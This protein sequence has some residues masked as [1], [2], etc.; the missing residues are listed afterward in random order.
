MAVNTDKKLMKTHKFL[1]TKNSIRALVHS[2]NKRKLAAFLAGVT[3]ALRREMRR[4]SLKIHSGQSELSMREVTE[5]GLLP[6][7]EKVA[8]EL[9][10]EFPLLKTVRFGFQKLLP[11]ASSLNKIIIAGNPGSRHPAEDVRLEQALHHGSLR[12]SQE[13][14]HKSERAPGHGGP[15]LEAAWCS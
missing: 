15:R 4:L 7:D 2:G 13:L 6:D 1:V 14:Q 9:E 3:W 12:L 11:R 5:N 8:K 10:Q